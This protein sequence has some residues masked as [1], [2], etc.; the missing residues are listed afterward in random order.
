MRHHVGVRLDPLDEA[1]RFQPLDDALARRK[2]VDLVELLGELRGAFRQA[3][4]I[5][6]VVEEIEAAFLVEHADAA[7]AVAIAD[8]EIVEIVRRRHLHRARALFR[9]GI[10]V[11]DD[12][13]L[14]ADQRQ[15]DVL[16]DQLLVALILR[17]HGHA[18][19]A[20]HGLRARRCDH[21]KGRGILG[22]ETFCLRS[23]SADTR[24][25]P[26]PRSAALRDRRSR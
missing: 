11:G 14:A 25:G 9:I 16:A 8:L 26:S 22:I 4:Q 3:L 7:Q 20:E 24:G 15:D 18:G 5:I 13:D 2:A 21:D 12:F 19:I 6:L 23:D 17:M 1:E 10:V